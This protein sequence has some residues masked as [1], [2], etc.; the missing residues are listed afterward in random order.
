MKL[1][2][3][4]LEDICEGWKNS[5]KEKECGNKVLGEHVMIVEVKPQLR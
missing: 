1:P 5:Q 4:N 3:P 2:C